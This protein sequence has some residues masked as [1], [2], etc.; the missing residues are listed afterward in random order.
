M[1][2]YFYLCIRS[3]LIV[4]I[5][6]KLLPIICVRGYNEKSVNAFGGRYDEGSCVEK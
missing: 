4:E 1:V 3:E 2:S 6:K 5:C